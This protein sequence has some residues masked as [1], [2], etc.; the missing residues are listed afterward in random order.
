MTIKLPKELQNTTA[1]YSHVLELFE[2]LIKGRNI[3][4]THTEDLLTLTGSER[5]FTFDVDYN[6]AGKAT[7]PVDPCEYRGTVPVMTSMLMEEYV[8][9]FGSIIQ[10]AVDYVDPESAL[11]FKSEQH[12]DSNITEDDVHNYKIDWNKWHDT[13]KESLDAFEF[14]NAADTCKKLGLTLFPECDEDD[15]TVKAG[16]LRQDIEQIVERLIALHELQWDGHT[17]SDDG[18]KIFEKCHAYRD[19]DGELYA[20]LKLR[21]TLSDNYFEPR[22]EIRVVKCEKDIP[23]FN[24]NLIAVGQFF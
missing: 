23:W 6:G 10:Q 4:M 8:D 3:T 9:W 14:D 16:F 20:G 5:S 22:I 11:L 24:I 12:D 21:Q 17:I 1:V 19:T 2:H 15:V 13:V 18:Y 7:F